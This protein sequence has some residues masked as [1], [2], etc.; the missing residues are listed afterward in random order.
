MFQYSCILYFF[1][2]KRIERVL[3]NFFVC[4]CVGWTC[5]IVSRLMQRVRQASCMPRAGCVEKAQDVQDRGW[6]CDFSLTSTL[7]IA[8]FVC[9]TFQANNISAN[10]MASSSNS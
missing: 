4:A 3:Q 1:L 10:N 8:S 7:L 2:K 5:G 6:T 9:F